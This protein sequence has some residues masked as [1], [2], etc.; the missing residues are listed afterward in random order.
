MAISATTAVRTR[1]RSVETATAPT[2]TPGNN[3]WMKRGGAARAAAEKAIADQ[4]AA[5]QRRAA[6]IGFMPFRYFTKVGT[7]NEIIVLDAELGPCFYEHTLQNPKNGYWNIH[8]SCPKEFELCPLCEG[9]PAINGAPGLRGKDSHYVMMLSCISLTPYSYTD[10]NGVAQNRPWSRL[11]LPVSA[12]DQAFFM[13]RFN[14]KGTLRGMHL[15]MSK[16]VKGGSSL[17][18]ME[19]VTSAETVEDSVTVPAFDG[20]HNEEEIL[21]SFGSAAVL[22]QQGKVL[23]PANMDAYPFDYA[24][25]FPKPSGADLRARYGGAAAPGSRAEAANHWGETPTQAAQGARLDDDIPF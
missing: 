20:F 4:Q 21:A 18:Q 14:G 24:L 2:A 9:T 19:L 15:L 17:G 1:S 5:A 3:D 6:G 12:G 25:L 8:E 22:D 11:L 23:K 16:Q 13:R 10:K 7:T